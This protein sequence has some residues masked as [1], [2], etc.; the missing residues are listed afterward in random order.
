[1]KSGLLPT[2][3]T[4]AFLV[5][6]FMSGCSRAPAKI[7]TSLDLGAAGRY[8]DGREAWWMQWVGSSRDHGTFC[9]SCHTA[10]PYALS[11][12]ALRFAKGDPNL[13]PNERLLIDDVI[14]RVRLWKETKPYYSEEGYDRKTPESRGT[15]SVL[16]ALV[17]ANYDTEQG[18]IS[19]DAHQAF[20]NMWNEQLTTGDLKGSWSWLQFDQEPW[21]AKDS[22]YYGA[23][24]AAIATGMAPEHYSASP[25]IQHNLAMLRGYL[26]DHAASQSTINRIFLLWASTKLPDLLTR[27]EQNAIIG[28]ALD[29]QQND[30]GWRLASITWSWRGWST[31]TL[32][33]MWL[34]E[35]GTP[36]RGK[37]DSVATGLTAYVLQEA[38]IRFDN[39]QL[40]KAILWLRHSQT[41]E[42]DWPANS[43][44]KRT[45]LSSNTRLFMNDAGTAFAVLALTSSQRKTT[46]M[47]SASNRPP[48]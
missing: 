8:L 3:M 18:H 11:R 13:S 4:V 26:R 5:F 15:E 7:S 35:D 20:E 48:N 16:N 27:A 24:L 33:K 39:A 10:L 34:S 9:V 25:E 38:G 2:G 1:M 41:P 14:K 17:L 12:P 21:E 37:S 43:V 29:R 31:K 22:V 40:Q 45:H 6:A 42:G 28:E 19:E 36:L 46:P 44:N 32:V 47:D 30:G 23:C